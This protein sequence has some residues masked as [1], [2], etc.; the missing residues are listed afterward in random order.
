M[1][2]FPVKLIPKPKLLEFISAGVGVS[3]HK[4]FALLPYVRMPVEKV[5]PSALFVPT[6]TPPTNRRAVASVTPPEMRTPVGNSIP[7]VSALIAVTRESPFMTL[8]QS[9]VPTVAS[10]AAVPGK[11]R[12]VHTWV[13]GLGEAEGLDEGLVLGLVE[14]EDDGLG[15][16]D[17]ELLGDD[18]GLVEGEDEGLVDGLEDGLGVA[19]GEEDG[20]ALGL[21]DG[22]LLGE[23]EGD[24]EGDGVAEGLELGD[25]EGDV[26]GEL[27][28]DGVADGL[29]L[30]LV[31]G[32]LL[33]DGVA[34]GEDDGE[35]EGDDEGEFD[36]VEPLTERVKAVEPT[37]AS[38]V[39][40][41]GSWSPIVP[42]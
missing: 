26:E 6:G 29:L 35:A 33:G 25:V 37:V 14:G 5:V 20:V 11:K 42:P 9:I 12:L 4:S 23:V 39:Q 21:L 15:V 13:P 7:P 28:G 16:A 22:L 31:E 40:L 41:P 24:E 34:E 2:P 38:N 19:L 32:E 17:G 8:T 36:T 30:G 18:E 27:L 10:F 3:P 1:P